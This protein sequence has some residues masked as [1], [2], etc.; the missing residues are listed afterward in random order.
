MGQKSR[1]IKR[2]KSCKEKGVNETKYSI[3]KMDFKTEMRVDLYLQ[4]KTKPSLIYFI[5]R[6]YQDRVYRIHKIFFLHCCVQFSLFLAGL[7]TYP[8]YTG[9]K[10]KE[11]QKQRPYYEHL[12][13]KNLYY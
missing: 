10:D 11:K 2:E 6:L 3:T 9:S 13:C 5:Y 12:N 4:N 1:M 7:C 8:R